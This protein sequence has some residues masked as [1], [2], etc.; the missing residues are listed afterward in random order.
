MENRGRE[1]WKLPTRAEY[2]TAGKRERFAGIVDSARA[3]FSRSLIS[4]RCAEILDRSARACATNQRRPCLRQQQPI[5]V[6][7][8]T[9]RDLRIRLPVAG[10]MLSRYRPPTGAF[11]LPSMKFRIVSESVGMG[12]QKVI[13]QS[14]SPSLRRDLRPLKKNPSKK[15]METR[16]AKVRQ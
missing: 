10:S 2:E 12:F 7:I 16:T 14:S 8:I 13:G 4:Q 6:P 1:E 3:S 11:K 5:D 15:E 9:V